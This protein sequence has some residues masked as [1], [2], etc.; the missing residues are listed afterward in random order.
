MQVDAAGKPVASTYGE[1]D[2]DAG[3]CEFLAEFRERTGAVRDVHV[4]DGHRSR[5]RAHAMDGSMG[6]RVL[7][8]HDVDARRIG[9][10]TV[11]IDAGLREAASE[12]REDTDAVE[13]IDAQKVEDL[14][15]GH[16]F[17]EDG[18]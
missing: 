17:V 16:D 11:D 14:A 1:L 4:H 7:A 8:G 2:A 3:A 5:L 18:A 6:R 15:V 10:E 12:S 9:D 13:D